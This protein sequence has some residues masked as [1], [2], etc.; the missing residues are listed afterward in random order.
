MVY[1]LLPGNDNMLYESP[2]SVKF[3]NDIDFIYIVF[4]TPPPPKT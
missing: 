1:L 2:Q 3:E 4:E